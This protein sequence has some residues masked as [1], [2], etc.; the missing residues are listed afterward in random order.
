MPKRALCESRVNVSGLGSY[1][2]PLSP[3]LHSLYMLSIKSCTQIYTLLQKPH[4][5]GLCKCGDQWSNIHEMKWVI[6]STYYMWI[7]W[8]NR[9]VKKAF[10][11]IIYLTLNYVHNYER[12]VNQGLVLALNGVVMLSSLSR[13]DTYESLWVLSS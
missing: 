3:P 6:L 5:T 9:L 10:I 7:V 12:F 13:Y 2:S 8:W 11:C 4:F 1:L